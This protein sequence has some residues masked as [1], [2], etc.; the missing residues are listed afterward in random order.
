MKKIKFVLMTLIMSMS[1]LTFSQNQDLLYLK[2]VHS[3]GEG[4][5][6]YEILQNSDFSFSFQKSSC[7]TQYN[8]QIRDYNIYDK[9]LIYEITFDN[10]IELYSY[11]ENKK[12]KGKSAYKKSAKYFI[13]QLDNISYIKGYNP[14]NQEIDLRLRQA[15]HYLIKSHNQAIQAS[16]FAIIGGTLYP[17][18]IHNNQDMFANVV[19]VGSGLTSLTFTVKSISNKRKGYKKLKL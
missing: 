14:T 12:N 2:N 13:E 7:K 17:I 3:S 19:V 5:I 16:V 11:L 8:I 6:L 10:F 18:L 15:S 9:K 4:K 1:L